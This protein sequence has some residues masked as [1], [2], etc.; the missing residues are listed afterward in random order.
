MW[1]ACTCRR[2]GRG[3]A[4]CNEKSKVQALDRTQPWP[5]LTFDKTE[6]RTHDYVRHGTVNL[7]GPLDVVTGK[8]ISE[9]YPRRGSQGFLAFMKT[10]A[11]T[12]VDRETHVVVD[13]LVSRKI[14]VFSLG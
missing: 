11:T 10:V 2:R 13:N 7:F 14:G 12:Y 5:P 4:V 3:G 9:C 8:I 1:S 6:K